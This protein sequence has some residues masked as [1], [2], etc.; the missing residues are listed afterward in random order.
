V[1]I[2]LDEVWHYLKFK[3]MSFGFGWHIVV[4]PVSFLSRDVGVVVVELFS[5]CWIGF[6]NGMCK[7]FLLIIGKVVWDLFFKICL[8]K[9]KQRHIVL[10]VIIFDSDIGLHV[11]AEKSVL[12]P[13]HYK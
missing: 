7:C 8:F 11:S 5:G 4:L 6:G 2:G 12:S 1:V 13:A 9:Q 3:K 10:S